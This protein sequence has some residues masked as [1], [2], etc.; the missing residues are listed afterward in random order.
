MRHTLMWVATAVTLT[1]VAVMAQPGQQA[2]Q[3]GQEQSKTPPAAG[4]GMQARQTQQMKA[5]EMRMER[6]RET[7]RTMDGSMTRVRELN[8]HMEQRGSPEGLREMGR[9]LEQAGEQMQSMLRTMDRLCTDPDMQKDQ[10]RLRDMDRL[11]D[12]LRTMTHEM[13]KT[14]DMLKKVVGA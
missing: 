10:D 9:N 1:S 12:R 4:K 3:M 14:C 11:H 2:R 5:Q 6:M 7:L 8:R 13:D